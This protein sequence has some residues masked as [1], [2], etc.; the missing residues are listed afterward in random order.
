[1][2][3]STGKAKQNAKIQEG[4]LMKFPLNQWFD[5]EKPI[6][7]SDADF[8][9]AQMMLYALKHEEDPDSPEC[10]KQYR[11]MRAAVRNHN[12]KLKDVCNQ[13]LAG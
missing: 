13:N 8:A 4:E 7:K 2:S 1:M 6:S 12:R 10:K 3:K 9:E 11:G 5:V